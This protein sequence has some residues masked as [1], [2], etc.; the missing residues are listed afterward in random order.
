MEKEILSMLDLYIYE[1]EKYKEML[2]RANGKVSQFIDIISIKTESDRKMAEAELQ[3]LVDYIRAQWNV[4]RI[5][6]MLENIRRVNTV[7]IDYKTRLIRASAIYSPVRWE[8]DWETVYYELEGKEVKVYRP[9]RIRVTGQDLPVSHYSI[10]INSARGVIAR[11]LQGFAY[12]VARDYGILKKV[13]TKKTVRDKFG[14]EKTVI[15]K[16]YVVDDQSDSFKRLYEN[17][18]EYGYKLWD[19]LK[20]EGWLFGK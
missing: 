11:V 13:E 17:A 5:Y 20:E 14:K 9:V 18:R 12:I 19:Y 7:R 10:V 3:K 8:Q 6:V 15:E 16:Y 1:L 2:M 4:R